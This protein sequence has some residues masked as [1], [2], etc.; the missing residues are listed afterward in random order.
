MYIDFSITFINYK[1]YD[2]KIASSTTKSIPMNITQS[3]LYGFD[4]VII[5][6]CIEQ[7]ASVRVHWIV[8]YGY[9]TNDLQ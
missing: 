3:G 8:A 1:K 9:I 2:K 5:P 6:R 4:A 7:Y